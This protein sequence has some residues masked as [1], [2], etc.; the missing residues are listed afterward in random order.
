MI[1]AQNPV[2]EEWFDLPE[3]TEVNEIIKD[4][5]SGE[6]FEVTAIEDNVATLEPVSV[7]E[8]WGE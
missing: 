4:P 8:D 5:N 3:G 7:E 2:T 1:Q 6:M